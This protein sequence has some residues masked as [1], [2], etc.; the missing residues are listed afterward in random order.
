MDEKSQVGMKTQGG[1]PT[2]VGVFMTPT[3]CVLA[4]SFKT[5]VSMF[6]GHGIGHPP[7]HQSQRSIVQ[8]A[9]SSRPHMC[10]QIEG[11][12]D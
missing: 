6:F 10:N 1:Y 5:R 4:V 12:Q 8:K 11:A 3:V 2:T 7:F 9:E